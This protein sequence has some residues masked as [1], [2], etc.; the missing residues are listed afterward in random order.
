M[1]F[2]DSSLYIINRSLYIT[3]FTDES[4]WYPGVSWLLWQR[5]LF[6]SEWFLGGLP[7]PLFITRPTCEGTLRGRPL[8][9]LGS[10]GSGTV[11]LILDLDKSLSSEEISPQLLCSSLSSGSTPPYRSVYRTLLYSFSFPKNY[12]LYCFIASDRMWLSSIDMTRASSVR[13][14]AKIL[15]AHSR[16]S[17]N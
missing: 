8:P 9:L 11:L 15:H 3:L 10:S 4:C 7:L 2:L 12:Q 13:N 1:L 5:R 6:E 17:S 16:F 14:Y